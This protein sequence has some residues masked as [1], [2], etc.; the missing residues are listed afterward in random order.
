ML[1]AN[2]PAC[3][4]TEKRRCNAVFVDGLLKNGGPA[5]EQFRALLG[6]EKAAEFLRKVMFR[7]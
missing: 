1:L 4:E 2:C 3:D 7:T 5:I 6:E